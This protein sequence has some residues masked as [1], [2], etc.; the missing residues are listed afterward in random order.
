MKK[1]LLFAATA[2]LSIYMLS[3]CRLAITDWNTH[4]Y[5]VWVNNSDHKISLSFEE[6]YGT[7]YRYMFENVILE[8]GEK[9]E[10]IVSIEGTYPPGWN[11][12]VTVLF[13]D[14]TYVAKYGY[15]VEKPTNYDW[16]YDPTLESNYAFE[17]VKNP[18]GCRQCPGKR[19]TYTFT[20]E[21]YEAAV[22]Y[23]P[24]TVK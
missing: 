3:G 24:R 15:G 13:D 14:G 6:Y 9:H 10:E 18:E 19:W 23:G 5:Y 22:A 8:P 11:W 4:N 12:R 7:S 2:L 16:H 21:D 17:E 1:I 20:D